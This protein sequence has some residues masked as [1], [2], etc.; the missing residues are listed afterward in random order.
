M[1]ISE[2]TLQNKEDISQPVIETFSFFKENACDLIADKVYLSPM[3]FF[4]MEENP[5]KLEKREYPIDFSYPWADKYIINIGIPEGYKAEILPEPSRV[6]LPEDLGSFLFN[7]NESGAMIQVMV[8]T[9]MTSAIL[10]A[11][12]YDTVREFFKQLVAKETEKIV[13]TKI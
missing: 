3:L 4:A 5:F 2:Y 1:E 10:P 8:Q 11:V 9:E 12:Y 7:I 6:T 13:L